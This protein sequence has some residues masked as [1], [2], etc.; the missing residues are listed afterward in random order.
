MGRFHKEYKVSP[1]KIKTNWHTQFG[2]LSI[3]LKLKYDWFV[4][5]RNPYERIISE[6]YYS[7]KSW[8]IKVELKSSIKF[9]NKYIKKK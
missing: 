9:F 7:I 5:I 1:K 2:L 8:N 3:E 4:V 6:F